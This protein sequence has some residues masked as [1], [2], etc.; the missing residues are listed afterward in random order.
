MLWGSYFCDISFWVAGSGGVAE[1]HG[2]FVN[3]V[4]LEELVGSLGVFTGQQNKKAG[5]EWVECAGVAYFDFVTKFGGEAT[6]DS[7]HYTEARNA[8]RFVYEDDSV[9]HNI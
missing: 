2:G 1:F 5:G 9:F 7:C 3:F 8:G 6:T 4:E